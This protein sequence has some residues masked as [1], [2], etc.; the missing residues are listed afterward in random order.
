MRKQRLSRLLVLDLTV[1]PEPSAFLTLAALV[2]LARAA[3]TA[4]G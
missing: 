1:T 2:C 3:R 4:S